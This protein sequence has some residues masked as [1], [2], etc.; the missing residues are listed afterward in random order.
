M[1]S[2][3]VLFYRSSSPHQVPDLHPH[4]VGSEEYY[5]DIVVAEVMAIVYEP[6]LFTL[7]DGI[8]RCLGIMCVKAG[9]Q[10][11]RCVAVKIS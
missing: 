2:P 5:M 9:L 10:T 7:H 11:V 6:T 3:L 8:V 4:A 1:S